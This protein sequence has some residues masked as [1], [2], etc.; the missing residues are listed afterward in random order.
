[1][2]KYLEIFWHFLLLGFISFG[3]PIAHLG[4]FRKK[5]VEQLRWLS[6]ES[7]AKIVALSQFLPGPSSSQVGFT[8]GLERGGVLGGTLV[9]V[10]FTLPSFLLLFF[11]ATLD[12][13][14]TDNAIVT[15]IIKG[16]KLFAVLIVADAT[17]SMFKNFCKDRLTQLIFI[18]ATLVLLLFEHFLMQIFVIIFAAFIGAWR[19]KTPTSIENNYKKPSLLPLLLFALLLFG[20]P[21]LATYS[22]VLDLFNTFYRV[23]SLVFGGGH[24]VLPLIGQNVAV[25]ENSFLVGY[26]LAQAV[27]GPMFTIAS[28]IGAVSFS[29][30]PFLGA[31]VATVAIFLSGFLLIIAFRQSFESYTQK[32]R[33][34]AAV[35]GINASVVAI[36]FAALIS[37]IFPSGV[38]SWY[39]L[40]VAV[41]GLLILR[42]FK[43]PVLYMIGAFC[44]V[45]I[46]INLKDFA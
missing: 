46:V 40:A 38:T 42:R 10:G 21:L 4:Y 29:S 17:L 43:I 33:I 3:G 1:M 35:I 30:N 34:A 16:L 9:F 27:P 37:P 31:V 7:Y 13:Q 25:D 12:I 5:F 22:P 14:Q 8:I 15:G 26:A 23:G 11:L 36:L 32:P 20:L 39:D 24:V 19:I 45:S 44:L 2:N 18:L 6:E 28:Y 41:I